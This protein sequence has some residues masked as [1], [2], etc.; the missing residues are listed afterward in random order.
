MEVTFH[1]SDPNPQSP[2]GDK[3]SGGRALDTSNS[4][5]FPAN[6][7]SRTSILS[8]PHPIIQQ[9][10]VENLPCARHLGRPR[11]EWPGS[12]FLQYS[13]S[14]QKE[15]LYPIQLCPAVSPSQCL[16]WS[17]A[18]GQYSTFAQQAGGGTNISLPTCLLLT[19]GDGHSVTHTWPS[20]HTQSTC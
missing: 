19:C 2:D 18:Q 7:F 17:L 8:R 9:T 14:T 13:V 1:P 3:Y 4:L 15:N 20:L 6:V 12:S 11:W 16:T 5:S 10:L